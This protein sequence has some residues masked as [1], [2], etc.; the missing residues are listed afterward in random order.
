MFEQNISDC[1]VFTKSQILSSE[2]NNSVLTLNS[3]VSFSTSLQSPNNF[4]P[5]SSDLSETSFKNMMEKVYKDHVEKRRKL[6]KLTVNNFNSSE[7]SQSL[8]TRENES[9]F[10]INWFSCSLKTPKVLKNQ[11]NKF[12][13][14]LDE[15][16]KKII[17][18]I[19]I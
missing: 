1:P 14:L 15:E 17:F 6:R 11:K 3:D 10:S 5:R 18:S 19:K 4:G 7:E 8:S 12:G 2:D 9:P 13:K 16:D